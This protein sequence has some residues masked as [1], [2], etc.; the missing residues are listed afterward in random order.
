MR[1]WM[2]ALAA[3]TLAAGLSRAME[4]LRPWSAPSLGELESTPF[5]FRD[6][7][8]AASGLRAA[9][10]DLAWVQLLQYMAG[11]LPGLADRPGRRHDRVLELS[12]RVFR[13]DPSFSRAVLYGAS[14]LGWFEEVD[15]PEEAGALLEEAI[16]RRPEEPLF[17]LYLAALAFKRRGDDAGMVALL[18]RSFDDPTTPTT[19]KA[20][21]ANLYARRGEDE[22]ALAAW[23]RILDEPRDEAEHG[24]ARQRIAELRQKRRAAPGAKAR[25]S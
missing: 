9:A 1:P 18:E 24:R 17:K 25:G 2:L 11:N 22:K 4:R 19:M 23:R 14:V 5:S 8:L 15:R 12:R 6:S 21:L 13:L 7:V 3:L 16:R 10:A 20:I